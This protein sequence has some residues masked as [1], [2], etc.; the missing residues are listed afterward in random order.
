MIRRKLE[1]TPYAGTNDVINRLM[2]DDDT[3]WIVQG[4]HGRVPVFADSVDEAKDRYVQKF[5]KRIA[6]EEDVT[7]DE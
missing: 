5:A 7:D 2:D 6:D 3:V 1:V 4:N